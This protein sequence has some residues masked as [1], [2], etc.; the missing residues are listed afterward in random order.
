MWWAC[1]PSPSD[2]IPPM[3][4]PP[5]VLAS[6]SP[7]RRQLLSLLGIDFTVVPSR[8]D[9]PLPE[10]EGDPERLAIA[11]AEAKARAI[12]PDRPGSLVIGADTLVM[13]GDRVLGKPQDAAAAAAMLRLLSGREHHVVTGV[14]VLDTRS[15]PWSVTTAAE[16]TAVRFR[17]LAE[18]EIAAY[19]ATGEP[20][21]KAGAYAIQGRGAILIEGIVGDYANV[22]GLPLVRTMELLRAAGVCILG[23]GGE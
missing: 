10:R 3:A 21:D 17:P 5:I 12:A 9:E 13:V 8:V 6:A 2:P 23:I 1:P 15:Q 16:R 14:A 11:L 7:R 19:V 18:A 22:V 20:M 4:L